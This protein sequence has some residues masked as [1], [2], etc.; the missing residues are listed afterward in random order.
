MFAAHAFF[1]LVNLIV[2]V[3]P[4]CHLQFLSAVVLTLDHV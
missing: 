2:G 1:L 4:S 3:A